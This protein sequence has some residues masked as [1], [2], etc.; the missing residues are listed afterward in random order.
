MFLISA[1][2]LIIFIWSHNVHLEGKAFQARNTSKAQISRV[3]VVRV[4]D[5]GN[6]TEAQLI[7]RNVS[8]IVQQIEIGAEE[9][10]LRVEELLRK[11]RE[12]FESGI[13]AKY[14]E[15][16]YKEVKG[17]PPSTGATD[18]KLFLKHK[19]ET[20]LFLPLTPS[21]PSLLASNKTD[22]RPST[23]LFLICKSRMD[24]FE[25]RSIVR[26]TWKT[27]EKQYSIKVIFILGTS[28]IFLT[29]EGENLQAK[30]KRE[31]GQY[32]DILQEEFV[33]TYE[34]LTLK[35]MFALKYVTRHLPNM[36]EWVMLVDDD[37]YVNVP[38]LLS[39][40]ESV[41]KSNVIIGRVR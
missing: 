36:T 41:S 20:S 30:I 38:S 27:F 9:K 31:S 13:M 8:K 17:W 14:N 23:K 39:F 5:S 26:K 2:V 18:L 33:D 28:S 1:S 21:P 15:K 16:C 12:R 3:N 29:K 35:S 25:R 40:M 10:I 4:K 22:A 34:N 32:G 37:S 11:E 19:T 6:L 7:M 24:A